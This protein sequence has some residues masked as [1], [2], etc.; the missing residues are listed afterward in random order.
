MPTAQSSPH[1][2]P[3][4]FRTATMCTIY[5][6]FPCGVGMC[7]CCP[8]R[9]I[10]WVFVGRLAARQ[11]LGLEHCV[12]IGPCVISCVVQL[13]VES[14]RNRKAVPIELRL[15]RRRKWWNTSAAEPTL[16]ACN[17]LECNLVAGCVC[18]LDR[19]QEGPR[20]KFCGR[21]SCSR[22]KGFRTRSSQTLEG[23]DAWHSGTDL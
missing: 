11:T 21:H 12:M 5:E 23:G 17:T 20:G 22:A 18:L 15:L 8:T 10:I 4:R 13:G 14:E 7:M 3:K 6:L 16:S 9:T 19:R 1:R 2:E